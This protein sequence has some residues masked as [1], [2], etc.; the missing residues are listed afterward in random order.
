MEEEEIIDF[1]EEN[2]DDFEILDF[3]TTIIKLAMNRLSADLDDKEIKAEYNK[4]NTVVNKLE[5]ILENYQ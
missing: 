1:I 2:L 3:G 4:L 5:K